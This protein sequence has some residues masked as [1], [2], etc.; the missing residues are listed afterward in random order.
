MYADSEPSN[1]VCPGETI[2]ALTNWSVSGTATSSGTLSSSDSDDYFKFQ[3]SAAGTLNISVSQTT[4]QNFY[5]DVSKSSCGDNSIYS[6]GQAL[7]H[8]VPSFTVVSGD[9]IYIHISRNK[10]INYTISINFQ[11]ADG[12]TCAG[13]NTLVSPYTATGSI[14]SNGTQNGWYKFTAPANPNGGNYVGVKVNYLNIDNQAEN[15]TMFLNEGVCGSQTTLSQAQRK[16]KKDGKNVSQNIYS[17]L[18][19]PNS[20]YYVQFRADTTSTTD[21]Q[22]QL[23]F[24]DPINRSATFKHPHPKDF[25]VPLVQTNVVGDLVS[26]GNSNYCTD[27]DRDGQCDVQG[28]ASL[29][30]G[31]QAGNVIPIIAETTTSIAANLPSALDSSSSYNNQSKATLSIPTGAKIKWAGLFWEGHIEDS[32]NTSK[33]AGG[34]LDQRRSAARSVVFKTPTGAASTKTAA[35]NSG[36]YNTS[37]TAVS[38]FRWLYT[39]ASFD[40]T[41][42]DVGNT[43]NDSQATYVSQYSGGT[44]KSVNLRS[45]NHKDAFLY[46]GFYNVTNDLKAVEAANGGNASGEY[47]V[48]NIVADTGYLIPIGVLGAWNLVIVYEDPAG[49]FRNVSV[50]DGFIALYDGKNDDAI[51]YATLN[52]S[53]MSGST[54][55]E[56]AA[57]LGIYH[58]T[59]QFDVS[60][61]YTPKAPA[62]VNSTLTMFIGDGEGSA[63]A[64]ETLHITQGDSESNGGTY[65]EVDN[66]P[67]WNGAIT[68]KDGTDNLNRSPNLTPV[69]AID[70]RN[71]QAQLSNEQTATTIK[72]AITSD[73]VILGVVGFSTDLYIPQLCYDY[74]FSQLGRFFQHDTSLTPHIHGV[75]YNTS[76]ISTSIMLRNMESGTEAENIKL[77]IDDLNST[78]ELEFF[79]DLNA[80]D[81]TIT[82]PDATAY[83]G[84]ASADISTLSKSDLKFNF[85]KSPNVLGYTQSIFTNFNIN[86]SSSGSIDVPLN[87]YIDFDYT[88]NGTT[89]SLTNL[90]F[91]NTIPRCT[92]S[93]SPYIPA[94]GIY[95]MVDSTLNPNVLD[96]ASNIKYNLPTQVA[97]RP[98]EMK[99]VSFDPLNP[100]TVKASSGVVAVEM[101]DVAGY[102]DINASCADPRSAITKQAWVVL[103]NTID[104][105]VTFANFDASLLETGLNLTVTTNE[106]YATARENTAFRI[107]YNLD[108][109]NGSVQIEEVTTG[110]YKLKNFTT[111]A[112]QVCAAD[113]ANGTDTVPQW[114]GNNGGGNGSGMTASDLSTCMK[115]IY[116][117]KSVSLCSRDNF[118]IRPEAFNIQI[119]DTVGGFS[120]VIPHEANLAAGYNYEFD[121]DATNHIS[122]NPT[123]GY[124]AIY[125]ASSGLDRNA[126]FYWEPN[127][128][129]SSGCNDTNNTNLD[130]YLSNG[131]TEDQNRS[132]PNIGRYELKMIDSAWTFIDKS[133]VHH[134]IGN[135]W[136]SGYDCISGSGVPLYSNVNSYNNNLVGCEISSTH[137]NLYTG[138]SYSDYNLTFR[139]HHFDFSLAFT[140]GTD[141]NTTLINQ[142]DWIYMNNITTDENMS[143]R[144]SGQISAKGA[145]GATVNNFVNN[146]YAEPLHLDVNL[147]FPTIAGLPNWRYRLQEINTSAA[148]WN[149][150]NAIIPAPATNA[151]FNLLTLAQTS[152]IK[153]QNGSLD[154]NLSI[155]FDRNQSLAV[156]PIEI[157]LENL[158]VKCQ[159]ASDCS[160]MANVS[161]SHEADANLSTNATIRHYYGRTNAPRQ[162][163][164]GN[165]GVVPIYYEVFCNGTGCDKNLLPDG[166]PSVSNDD[167]RWFVNTSHMPS[168]SGVVGT[169]SQ[170]NSLG[171]VSETASTNAN[172][173]LSTLTYNA[174]ATKGYPYKTTMENNASS[175]LIYNRYN[176]NDTNNEF[177][178]EF[179][180]TGG[181]WAGKHETN[182]TTNPDA[183]NRTN[184]RTTW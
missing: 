149:D 109:N 60:G 48:S 142:T 76:P 37:S 70:I 71:F 153:E 93:P 26:I 87:L 99:I 127:G 106:F 39:H 72:M 18:L 179:L 183:S 144:Y 66:G 84:V 174:A 69:M 121:I 114:C 111:Y 59:M 104:E 140:K 136:I 147:T 40:P 50:N 176:I 112:G 180:G 29:T 42:Q 137:S 119:K 96:G 125:N 139:P 83:Y 73:R 89:Y 8:S 148:I 160:S 126:T 17:S 94:V 28:T 53:A 122:S 55:A 129:I 61:F 24:Y 116:G 98:T 80:L 90:P 92:A 177:E 47:T 86:P 170:K 155:N 9:W 159:I 44:T 118:S 81:L 30:Q 5:F 115:C 21:Y 52:G 20:T 167:P 34:A 43:E 143:I 166:T 110:R 108:D 74:S 63:T 117:L 14:K 134:V 88:L 41:E 120:N 169:I 135:N 56:K 79:T 49:T 130:F 12:T 64:A 171:T 31:N 175:W 156:N 38:D 131:S 33:D 27:F 145:D 22:L 103:G 162:V 182:T 1:N 78:N 132:N 97:S 102:Y 100:D 91:A 68:N 67:G 3:M 51:T 16:G 158:Q 163:F 65:I 57:S 77:F 2:S 10:T 173:Y 178:V 13:A 11:K 146:C 141:F 32:S 181:G 184:R 36:L 151:S 54:D 23:S 35:I 157:G 124:T 133:P 101:I 123:P 85:L 15:V 107:S 82:N 6:G 161:F 138:I 128:H 150:N 45:W 58:R 25:S 165:T 172:P 95:N 168:S 75:L 152:F 62:T 7:S 4:A 46:Q 113:I 164:I 105:N 154:M 19:A